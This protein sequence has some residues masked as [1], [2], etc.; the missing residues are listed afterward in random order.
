MRTS[1]FT[2]CQSRG[3]INIRGTA[4]DTLGKSQNNEAGGIADVRLHRRTSGKRYA[5]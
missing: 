1:L 4:W 3:H 5:F 2:T